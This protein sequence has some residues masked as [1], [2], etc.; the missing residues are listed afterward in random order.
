MRYFVSK[1]V[2]Y[3]WDEA[4]KSYDNLKAL[5]E[6]HTCSYFHNTQPLSD[7]DKEQQ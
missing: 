5:D 7:H 3:V 1:K 4:T 6:G 2:K